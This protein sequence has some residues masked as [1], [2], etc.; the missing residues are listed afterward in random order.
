MEINN[1]FKLP[2]IAN[3]KERKTKIKKK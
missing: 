2:V 1:I 3:P